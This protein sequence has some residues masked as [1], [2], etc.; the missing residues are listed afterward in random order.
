[1]ELKIISN[2]NFINIIGIFIA[3]ISLV[4]TIWHSVHSNRT[5]RKTETIRVLK[6]IRINYPSI[7]NMNFYQKINYMQEV[8]FFATG[9]NEGI[10]DIA[11]VKKMSGSLLKQQY[12]KWIKGYI[13]ST[14]DKQKNDKV[15]I[16]FE[17]MI[18]KL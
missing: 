6:S 5:E 17:K 9:V 4:F 18:E 10:Y 1:M 7:Y 14:R 13:H 12:N 8:E 15:Y 3:L 16:E 11:I 2:I